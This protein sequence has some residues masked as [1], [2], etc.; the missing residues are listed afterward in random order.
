MGPP[1]PRGEKGCQGNQG[2][3][4]TRGDPGEQ[5]PVGPPGSFLKGPISSCPD[6]FPCRTCIP[7][8]LSLHAGDVL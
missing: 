5:G 2:V 6:G 7:G 3:E 4:G 1:G 8:K